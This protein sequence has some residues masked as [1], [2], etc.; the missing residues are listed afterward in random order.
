MN[1][2]QKWS[3]LIWF[4]IC[5]TVYLIQKA[6]QQIKSPTCYEQFQQCHQRES[7]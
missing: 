1:K 7:K 5:L 6:S 4:L 3:L 2:D